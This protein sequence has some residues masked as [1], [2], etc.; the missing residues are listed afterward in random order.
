[1][2]RKKKIRR[3]FL[4]A[5]CIYIIINMLIFG[6]MRAYLNTNNIVSRDKIAMATLSQNAEKTEINILGKKFSIYKNHNA[7]NL[8]QAFLY[9]LLPYN[10][11]ACTEIVIRCENALF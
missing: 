6:L 11:R 5:L 4:L 2:H 7:K 9:I 10:V 3:A 1:M 8:A